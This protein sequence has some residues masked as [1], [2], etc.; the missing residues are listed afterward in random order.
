MTP[1]VPTL[2]PARSVACSN[3]EKT[4][5]RRER[6]VMMESCFTERE[7]PRIDFRSRPRCN[8]CKAAG[9]AVSGLKH[10]RTCTEQCDMVVLSVFQPVGPCTQRSTAIPEQKHFICLNF[11][12]LLFQRFRACCERAESVFTMVVLLSG[13]IKPRSESDVTYRM[14]EQRVSLSLRAN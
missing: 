5:W 3:S 2:T 12:S 9:C 10:T 1:V 6:K 14:R 4:S 13:R 7:R 8:A 11:S